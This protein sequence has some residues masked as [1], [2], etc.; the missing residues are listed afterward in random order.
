MKKLLLFLCAIG[1]A[2]GMVSPA[3]ADMLVADIDPPNTDTNP[4]V[5]P[6]SGQATETAWL[7]I[8]TSLY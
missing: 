4:Q 7:E 6:N 3:A 5:L 2:F 8:G 1:L